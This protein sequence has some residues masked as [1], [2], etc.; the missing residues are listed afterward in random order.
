M[1]TAFLVAIE[2]VLVKL[3]ETGPAARDDNVLQLVKLLDLFVFA[4]LAHRLDDLVGQR[5][6][7]LRSIDVFRAQC[8]VP[9]FSLRLRRLVRLD[10]E[11]VEC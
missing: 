6:L 1:S 11:V 5:V 3:A 2:V 10:L 8:L 4:V 9:N 7:F